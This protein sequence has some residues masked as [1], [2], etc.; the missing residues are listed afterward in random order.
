LEWPT[1]P[2]NKVIES[3]VRIFC[4]IVLIFVELFKC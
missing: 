1:N 2:K 4:F 3:I